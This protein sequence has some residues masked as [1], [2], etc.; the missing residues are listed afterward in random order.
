M[1][2]MHRLMYTIA[3]STVLTACQVNPADIG[4][5]FGIGGG[6]GSGVHFGTGINIPI[7]VLSGGQSSSNSGIRV[8]DEAIVSYFDS[9]QGHYQ[10]SNK[11][12][13]GGFYRKLLGKQGSQWLVQDFYFDTGR[14]YN[15][16]MLLNPNQVYQFDSLPPS[17][18]FYTYHAN[19]Q[20][21]SKREY[22]N[23]RLRSAQAWNVNGQSIY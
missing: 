12:I 8:Q 4:L 5:G 15:E 21:A 3:I 10:A 20:L 19:G 9:A 13:R 14:K 23:Q 7:R 6:S 11:P 1:K 22:V 2:S 18:T 16:P 17:G